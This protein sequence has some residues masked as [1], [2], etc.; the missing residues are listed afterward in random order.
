MENAMT[1]K[2]LP[3]LAILG[4]FATAAQSQ[5]EPVATASAGNLTMP[6]A[7]T[8]VRTSTTPEAYARDVMCQSGY[9][10]EAI[11]HCIAR[12]TP[13]SASVAAATE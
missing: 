8:Q 4:M 9:V 5:G 3:S 1:C 2:L 7:P 11:A 6:T 10:D 12:Q 13:A